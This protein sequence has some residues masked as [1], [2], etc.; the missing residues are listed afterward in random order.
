MQRRAYESYVSEVN[1]LGELYSDL[2]K[3][4]CKPYQSF[5]AKVTPK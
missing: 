5:A 4:A 3:E 2:A 1:K